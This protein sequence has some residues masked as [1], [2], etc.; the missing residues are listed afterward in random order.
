[1]QSFLAAFLIYLY[2]QFLSFLQIAFKF[3]RFQ[4]YSRSNCSWNN[5]SILYIVWFSGRF[6]YMH[7]VTMNLLILKSWNPLNSVF[8][9]ALSMAYIL[10]PSFD[11]P[12]SIIFVVIFSFIILHVYVVLALWNGRICSMV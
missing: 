1:M 12:T 8:L 10:S 2:W 3:V 11:V 4:S 9:F 6:L 5:F 7:L